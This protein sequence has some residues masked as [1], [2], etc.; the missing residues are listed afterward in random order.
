MVVASF[1]GTGI[2]IITIIFYC[3][4]AGG[5]LIAAASVYIA[6][7]AWIRPRLQRV[8]A[9]ERMASPRS[10][11]C[12][13]PGLGCN[14]EDRQYSACRRT[15]A[16]ENATVAEHEELEDTWARYN[17]IPSY[18]R[19]AKAKAHAAYSRV[20]DGIIARTLQEMGDS[21]RTTENNLKNAN[22]RLLKSGAVEGEEE[23]SVN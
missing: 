19:R 21:F 5:V 20:R 11:P 4:L 9:G 14:D 7:G 1:R 10:S 15:K 22:G 16:R 3:A 18:R 23:Y 13:P 6:F 17:A 2:D 8:A 12:C